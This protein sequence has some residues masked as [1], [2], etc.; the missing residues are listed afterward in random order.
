MNCSTCNAVNQVGNFCNQCGAE[1]AQSKR[2][3]QNC[4]N[5]EI[6]GE[7][8]HKC[9]SQVAA[10]NECKNCNAVDQTG[11]FCRKCGSEISNDGEATNQSAKEPKIT[12][13]KCGKVS[14]RYDKNGF[15]VWSC[16]FCGAGEQHIEWTA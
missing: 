12:C 7:Y 3:C 5:Q 15:L 16:G 2:P 9:G 11:K 8:C 14:N 10:S 6:L 1:L 13:S 4:G